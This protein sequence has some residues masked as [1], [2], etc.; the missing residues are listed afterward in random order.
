MSDRAV[1]RTV[2]LAVVV[3]SVTAGVA[4]AGRGGFHGGGGGIHPASGGFHPAAGGFHPGGSSAPVHHPA[5]TFSAPRAAPRPENFDV[6]R[7]IQ[8]GHVNV[9]TFNR[10]TVINRTT[11]VNNITRVNTFN[12]GYGWR[13]PYGGYHSNWVHGYWNGHYY[14]RGWG[15]GWGGWGYPYGYAAWGL[16]GFGLGLATGIG[17]WGLG[18]ALYNWGYSNYYNPYYAGVPVAVQQPVVVAQASPY[19]YAQPIDTLAAPPDEAAADAALQTFESARQA[20]KGGDYNQA[21]ALA[22]QALKA[23]PNDPS[24]HEFRALV[25]FAIGQYDQAAAPLYAVLSNGPG[26]DW[27]TLIGLYPSIDVYTNQLRALEDYVRSHPD[28]ASGHFVVAYH[29]LT[30]GHTD[31]TVAQ[32][33]RVV[34]LQPGDKLSVQLLHQLTAPTEAPAA[35]GQ[36]PGGAQPQPQPQP[37]GATVPDGN[38]VGTWTASPAQGTN[39]TLTVGQDGSFTWKVDAQG[40]SRPFTGTSTFGNGILTLAQAQG[41]PMVGH[42]TWLDPNHFK[43]Q[44]AGGPDDPGLTF[45]RAS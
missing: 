11:N 31:A 9:N 35:A 20:F 16:G 42:V 28:S 25:L 13:G 41:P 30:Q 33:Q 22:D 39:V 12:G 34:A 37:A 43:F 29:Y 14:P 10:N 36:P 27:T 26:W 40:Q 45:T 5:P 38:L 23:M 21:L 7:G 32:L 1:C 3:L 2:G 8:A 24:L 6:N 15:W 19:N 4:V 44:V 17:A 18:S